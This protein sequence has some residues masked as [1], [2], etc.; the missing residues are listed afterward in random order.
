ME[1]DFKIFSNHITIGNF[2]EIKKFLELSKLNI[3]FKF[4]DRNGSIGLI[5]ID[6]SKS[7][8]IKF[9]SGDKINSNDI[10]ISS[11]FISKISFNNI[12]DLDVKDIINKANEIL[13][14]ERIETSIYFLLPLRAMNRCINIEEEL[15][16]KMQ[17][18]F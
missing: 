12:Y 11:R 8:S 18:E 15:I 1:N 3:D 10:K 2:L 7:N 13:N 9:V 4:N 5:G 6:D 14:K 16:L 17:K